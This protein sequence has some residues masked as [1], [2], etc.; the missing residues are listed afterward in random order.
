MMLA[1]S[2]KQPWPWAI[3][4]AGKDIE[5]RDWAWP[6]KRVPLPKRVLIHASKTFSPDDYAFG[7]VAVW[8]IAH[9][10]LPLINELVTGAIIGA[11][12]V[13]S[14][15]TSSESQWFAG[16]FGFVL[17]RPVLLARPIPCRGQLG[18]WPVSDDIEAEVRAAVKG[19][20]A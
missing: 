17:E 4:H 3:F 16:K 20:S 19:T 6:V 13:T 5:N 10:D 11:V 1:L 7:G 2:V 14:C 8:Q 9:L 18:L 15:V 12:T